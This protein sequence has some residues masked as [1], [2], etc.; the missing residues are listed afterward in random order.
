MLWRRDARIGEHGNSPSIR[1]RVHEKLQTLAVQLG[2]KNADSCD[3]AAR[4]RKRTHESRPYHVIRNAHDRNSPRGGLCRSYR[5][6]ARGQDSIGSRRN[7]LHRQ[8][9]ITVLSGAEPAR[10]NGQ[11]LSF[12]NSGLPQFLEKGHKVWFVPATST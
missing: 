3:V 2:G 12:D 10:I 6:I 1:K 9:W 8:R 5:R 7:E 4:T 11:L